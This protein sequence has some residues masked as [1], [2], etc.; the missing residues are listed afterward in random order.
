MLLLYLGLTGAC[1]EET[2][3]RLAWAYLSLAETP[4]WG[5]SSHGLSPPDLCHATALNKVDS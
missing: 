2:E 4:K 3:A 5:V 1:G